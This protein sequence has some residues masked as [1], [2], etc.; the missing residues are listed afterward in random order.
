M[1]LGFMDKMIQPILDGTKVHSFRVNQ[2]WQA[3]MKI[4]FFAKVRQSGM[5]QFREPTAVVTTQLAVITEEAVLLDGRVLLPLELE[6]FARADGFCDSDEMRSFF[7]LR[8]LP[9][10]GQLI[11]WTSLRY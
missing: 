7:A 4:H 1:I 2:R 8:R 11:H 9:L 6:T 3:G 5:Y 10:H